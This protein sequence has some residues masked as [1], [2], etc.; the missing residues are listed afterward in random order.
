MDKLACMSISSD[1]GPVHEKPW[2]ANPGN[3]FD[4]RLVLKSPTD[5][6][7]WAVAAGVTCQWYSSEVPLLASCH[8]ARFQ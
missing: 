7:H 5:K 2:I 3:N 1:L 8:P 6:M 4:G